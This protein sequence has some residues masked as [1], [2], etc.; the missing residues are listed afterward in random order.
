MNSGLDEVILTEIASSSNADVEDVRNLYQ[1]I[2][3]DLHGKARIHDF[4]PLLAMNRVREHFRLMPKQALK[5][6]NDEIRIDIGCEKTGHHLGLI[7]TN[8]AQ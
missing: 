2:V 7:M 5:N 8:Y 6:Q 1:S 4:I 3:G